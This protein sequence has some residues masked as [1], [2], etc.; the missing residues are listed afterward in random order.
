MIRRF[1]YFLLFDFLALLA[2]FNTS[3]VFGV[4]FNY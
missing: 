4:H 2:S 3:Y 1:E